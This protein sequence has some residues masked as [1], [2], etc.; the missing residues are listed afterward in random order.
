M[1][2]HQTLSAISCQ[3]NFL[4]FKFLLFSFL[5]S[6]LMNEPLLAQQDKPAFSWPDGK[7]IAVSLTFDDARLSQVDVGTSLLNQCREKA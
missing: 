7:Q 4:R 1:K 5:F 2:V 3:K 6:I